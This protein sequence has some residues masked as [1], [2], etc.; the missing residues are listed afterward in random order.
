MSDGCKIWNAKCENLNTQCNNGNWYGP[1]E[2]GKV[3]TPLAATI[4]APP[5]LG[6]TRAPDPNG[7]KYYA[8]YG[9]ANSGTAY[10]PPPPASEN[11]APPPP[12]SSQYDSAPAAPPPPQSSN[13]VAPEEE[14][15]KEEAPPSPP[16]QEVKEG[17]KPQQGHGKPITGWKQ[18]CPPKWK[19]CFMVP[20]AS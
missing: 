10:A 15:K 7:G 9:V 20:F 16:P 1:P 4:N 8:N 12:P 13:Y 14:A 18:I 11:Y 17:S 6:P 2:P 3:L 19:N 5:P